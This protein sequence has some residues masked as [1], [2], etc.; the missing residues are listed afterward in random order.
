V[1]VKHRTEQVYDDEMS[2][3]V[4]Q[5]IA[6]ARREGIPLLVSAG[7]LDP[8]GDGLMCNTLICHGRGHPGFMGG[9]ENRLGLALGVIQGHSGFDT[10]SALV[11][12]R[13]HNDPP[14]GGDA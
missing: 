11:I 9:I 1:T 3:L 4:T 14:A 13:H 6:I 5:L 7:M 8:D 12:T 10:A 2:P